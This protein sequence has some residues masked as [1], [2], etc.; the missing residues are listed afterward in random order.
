MRT[1]LAYLRQNAFTRQRDA[2]CRLMPSE[3]LTSEIIAAAM[4]SIERLGP[5]LLESAYQSLLVPRTGV[6][7]GLT[8]GSRVDLPVTYKGVKLDCGYRIDLVVEDKVV[9]ELKSV[10]AYVASS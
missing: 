2:H 1:H 3:S 10:R 5:G 6:S 8:F 4:K 7:A 9:V